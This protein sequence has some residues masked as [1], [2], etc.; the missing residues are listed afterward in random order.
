M[1]VLLGSLLLQLLASHV[2]LLSS[3]IYVD[4]PFEVFV[5]L[6]QV[7]NLTFVVVDGVSLRN[8]LFGQFSVLKVDVFLNLLNVYK[9]KNKSSNSL[10][11]A[12][13]CAL[14][15]NSSSFRS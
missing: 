2:L 3:L 5:H 15:L 8:C 7:C 10:L 4:V 12:S 6:L 11:W 13:F 1:L 9:Y 14:S